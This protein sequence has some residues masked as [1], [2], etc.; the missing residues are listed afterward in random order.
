[1]IINVESINSGGISPL[2]WT[3]MW[4]PSD[5]GLRPRGRWI[6][7]IKWANQGQAPP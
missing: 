5:L 6:I 2:K 3:C 7:D 1:M 4:Y